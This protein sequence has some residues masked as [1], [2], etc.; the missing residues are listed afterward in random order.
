MDQILQSPRAILGR[1]ESKNRKV[2]CAATTAILTSAMQ[3]DS[4][5]KENLAIATKVLEW[6]DETMLSCEKENCCM[7]LC[8]LR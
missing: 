6:N 4:D 2:T 5:S 8:T 7:M 1:S 3:A